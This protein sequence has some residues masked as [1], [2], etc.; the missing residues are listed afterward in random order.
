MRQRLLYAGV[1]GPLFFIVV[2]LIEGFT[3]PGYSQW[4]NFVS[5]LATGDGGW[6]QVVNFY[7]CGLSILLFAIG[8]RMT[9]KGTRGGAAAPIMFG[10]FALG[11]LVAG[12]FSTDPA[13]GYPPGQASVQT[14]HG[15]I[16]GVAGL[17]CFTV[18]AATCFVMAAHFAWVTGE[19]RWAL[20]SIVV[21]VVV[22]VFFF[23]S[24]FSSQADMSGSWPNAPTG[25]FQRIAILTGFT[26]ISIV[27]WRFASRLDPQ[28]SDMPHQAAA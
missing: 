28:R 5:Q 24:G 6:V 27:A 19:G 7:V 22:L 3:R 2:F 26:W 13:L 23:A 17:I 12:T 11:L 15:A 16:H 21:G 18:L 20:Y 25:F 9:I 1:L 8:L 4:R 10:V 14:V